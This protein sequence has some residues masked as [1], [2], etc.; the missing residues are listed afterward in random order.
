MT[1]PVLHTLRLTLRAPVFADFAAYAAFLASPRAAYMGGPY[2]PK[3]AWGVFCHQVAGW[4]IFGHG[5][6][7]VL[8]KDTGEAIGMVEIN[9]GPLFPEV[10]L[11]WQLYEG[12]EGQGYATEAARA[13][14]DWGFA[15]LPVSSLVSYTD[16]ENHPSQA[17]ARRLGAVI[18]AKAPVQD[19]GDLVWRHLRGTP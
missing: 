9:G 7:T 19:D 11:G 1:P 18:D 3:A 13:L 8:R 17:V 14:R 5:G 6:L 15:N 2:S 12:H 10:E 16:P 4:Q